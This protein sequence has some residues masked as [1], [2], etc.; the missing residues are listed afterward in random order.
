M[1]R[2]LGLALVALLTVTVC[3]S[4]AFAHTSKSSF[5][6]FA[7]TGGVEGPDEAMASN[8]DVVV[9]VASGTMDVT[10]K[11]ATGGGTFVHMSGG[12]VLGHGT[13]TATRLLSFQSYGCGV[14][15]GEPIPDNL[16]GG[17][18]LIAVHIVGHPAGGGTVRLDGILTV[19]CLVG[20][21]PAGHHEGVRLTVKDLINFNKSIE[22]ETLFVSA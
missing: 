19:D 18:A 14:A 22:G 13:F 15:G 6:W 8:G 12:T 20:N 11:T 21:P 4:S 2:S 7:G 5:Q 1:K 17:K 16:C 10:S 3:A 9:I